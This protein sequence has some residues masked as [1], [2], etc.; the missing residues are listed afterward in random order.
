MTVEQLINILAST[1]STRWPECWWGAGPG[2][3]S[4]VGNA[5]KRHARG[6]RRPGLMGSDGMG[7]GAVRVGWVFGCRFGFED[8]SNRYLF[9]PSGR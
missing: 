3:I 1:H 9:P 6:G 8:S 4:K 5:S 7:A 2:H